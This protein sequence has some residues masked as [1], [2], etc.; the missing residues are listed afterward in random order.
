MV[1]ARKRCQV[2]AN[3][4]G[5]ANWRIVTHLQKLILNLRDARC[6]PLSLDANARA[7]MRGACGTLNI[8]RW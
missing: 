5:R 8:G 7:L 1:A 4:S 2:S 6:L 3:E